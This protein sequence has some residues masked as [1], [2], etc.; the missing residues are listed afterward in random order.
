MRQ[1]GSQQAAAGMRHEALCHA[2]AAQ[3]CGLA[4]F[5]DWHWL[6]EKRR[7]VRVMCVVHC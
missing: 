7:M 3:F 4:Q 2:V 6:L 5:V 1:Q